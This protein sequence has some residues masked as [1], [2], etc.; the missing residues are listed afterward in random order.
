MCRSDCFTSTTSNLVLLPSLFRQCLPLLPCFVVFTCR[1]FC[2]TRVIR[3]C[4]TCQNSK[5]LRRSL[6]RPGPGGILH[7]WF[8][9]QKAH[10][11]SGWKRRQRTVAPDCSQMSRHKKSL[12]RFRT[13]ACPS[14][15][16]H[17]AQRDILHVTTHTRPARLSLAP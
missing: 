15:T 12:Q 10:I 9:A 2:N 14:K 11:V 7:F 4:G 6:A 5:L 8:T 3:G 17:H 13:V 1:G 16:H